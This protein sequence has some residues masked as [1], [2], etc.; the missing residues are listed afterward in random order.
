MASSVSATEAASSLASM[1]LRRR[2]PAVS[3]RRILRPRHCHSTRIESRVMPASGPVSIRSSPTR[4]LSRV[5]LPTLG[6]PTIASIIG[7][8]AASAASASSTC[9]TSH[10][11]GVL[12]VRHRLDVLAERLVQIA[13][14]L[15]MLG[16]D[17]DRLAEAQAMRFGQA[18]LAGA[19]LA[20]VG[21]QDHLGGALAQPVGEALVE[22]QDAGARVDQEQHDVGPSMARSVKRRMRA[23]SASPP[24]VSQPAVSSKV[25]ARSPS[26]PAIRAR[27]A[28]RRA[29]RRRWRGA[30]RPGD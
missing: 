28:S 29:C 6:R 16:R 26:W 15:G 9:S 4:R 12:L 30:C 11:R 2:M 23:S 25:K 21:D 10:V 14:A 1:R 3:I 13:Q 27:R 18:V 17:R 20:L 19:A 24:I 22:R 5:D 8:L 7:R